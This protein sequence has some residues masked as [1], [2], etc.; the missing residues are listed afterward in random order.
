MKVK[1]G[2]ELKDIDVGKIVESNKVK[3]SN[4]TAK[5]FI[6]YVDDNSVIPLCLILPQMTGWI[7]YFYNGGKNM[8]FKIEDDDVYL[9]YNEIW[10]K[11]KELLG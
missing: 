3:V 4:E 9:K 5:Y 6:G 8:S 2:I 10:N 11:I 1:K 7:K